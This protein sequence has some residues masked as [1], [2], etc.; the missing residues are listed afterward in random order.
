MEIHRP[1]LGIRIVRLSFLNHQLMRLPPIFQWAHSGYYIAAKIT[2]PVP[3]AFGHKTPGKMKE[4][5]PNVAHQMI[6]IP[7]AGQFTFTMDC[8]R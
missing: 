7:L 1:W 2:G 6:Y 4:R 3:K 8:G 5:S